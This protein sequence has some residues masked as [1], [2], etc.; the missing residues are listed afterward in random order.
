MSNHLHLA[1]AY[2]KELL[3]PGDL[4]IDATCG[5]G[6][7]S[8]Y[9]NSLGAQVIGYDIQQEAI[10]SA[11]ARVPNGIFHLRSHAQ[12][13]EE[14]AKLIVYNL[15]YLPGGNKSITTRV[16]TTFQSVKSA[17]KIATA[18]SITCYPGHPEGAREEELLVEFVKM[19]DPRL[20]IVCYHQ[21]LNRNKAPSLILLKKNL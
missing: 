17:I 21:W 18:V 13:V 4:A 12:F 19:L 5:N 9:L 8:E 7:D 6:Y 14:E 1:H 16:E 20:W 10:E 11:R 15:G 3:N 2:W